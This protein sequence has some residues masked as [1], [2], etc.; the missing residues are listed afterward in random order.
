[1]VQEVRLLLGTKF[2][3]EGYKPLL[4]RMLIIALMVV[5]YANHDGYIGEVIMYDRALSTAER[6][7]D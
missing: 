2:A 6:Q 4:N 3:E 1:M 7:K 5:F